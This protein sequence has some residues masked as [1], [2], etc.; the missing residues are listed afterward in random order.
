[1]EEWRSG[2]VG[3]MAANRCDDLAPALRTMKD[4]GAAKLQGKRELSL[5]NLS[6]ARGDVAAFQAIKPD[7]ANASSRV[8]EKLSAKRGEKRGKR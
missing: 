8:G 2:G 6:H 3:K 7:L 4:D 5:E 1:M